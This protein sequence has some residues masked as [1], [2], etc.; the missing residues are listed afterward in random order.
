MTTFQHTVNTVSNHILPDLYDQADLTVDIKYHSVEP[1]KPESAKIKPRSNW[2]MRTVKFGA[3]MLLLTTPALVAKGVG[4]MNRDREPAFAQPAPLLS[5]QDWTCDPVM[6]HTIN[7]SRLEKSDYQFANPTLAAIHWYDNHCL[8]QDDLVSVLADEIGLPQSVLAKPMVL[9]N[10]EPLRRSLVKTLD[11]SQKA[12]IEKQVNT[13]LKESGFQIYQLALTLLLGGA[14]LKNVFRKQAFHPIQLRYSQEAD[15]PSYIKVKVP[16]NDPYNLIVRRC[17]FNYLRKNVL[18]NLANIEFSQA[19]VDHLRSR[20]VNPRLV[21]V[22]EGV[23]IDKV[24]LPHGCYGEWVTPTAAH[25]KDKVILYFFGGAYIIGH[26]TSHRRITGNLARETNAPLLAVDYR[27]VPE[28][29]YPAALDDG[30]SAYQ[31]LLEQGYQPENIVIAGDSSGGHLA[32]SVLQ[33][34]RDQDIPQ[35]GAVGLIC[36]FTDMTMVSESIKKQAHRDPVLPAERME[37]IVDLFAGEHPREIPT[38]SPLHGDYE[39]APDFF[40]V[41]GERDILCDD[42]IRLAHIVNRANVDVECHVWRSMPHVFPML[43]KFL[44]EARQAIKELAGFIQDRLG[45]EGI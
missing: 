10:P 32:L 44:P 18:T 43:D 4:M 14:L 9:E 23:S 26:P 21:G 20:G 12:D 33:H 13:Q 3:S 8:N 5:Q 24:D 2:F 40:I 11:E 42:A 37:M 39:G 19:S 22:P 34:L 25:D 30:V 15:N 38:I 29:P 27:K 1:V 17:V 35:P 36:P 16:R 45:I 41:A 28:N 6:P 7:H 31:Y